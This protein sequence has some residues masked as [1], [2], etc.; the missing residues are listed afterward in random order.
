METELLDTIAERFAKK[1]TKNVMRKVSKIVFKALK[2]EFKTGWIE[3][4][5]VTPTPDFCRDEC[6]VWNIEYRC[7]ECTRSEFD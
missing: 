6:K 7:K 2:E 5:S 3:S 1:E 4:S